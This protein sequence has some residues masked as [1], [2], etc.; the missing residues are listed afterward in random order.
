MP[1]RAA[2]PLLLTLGAA[3][4]L[5]GA[6]SAAW[7]DEVY[8]QIEAERGEGPALERAQDWAQSFSELRGF[9]LPGGWFGLVLGPLERDEAVAR[10][11]ELKAQ[12]VIP[13]DSFIAEGD[14]YRAPFWP[15][16][17]APAGMESGA[18][19]VTGST[20]TPPPET[21]TPTTTTPA[22]VVEPE[23]EP[24]PDPAQLLAEARRAGRAAEAELDRADRM[25]LQRLL[26]FAGA[27]RG[28]IDGDFGPGTRGAIREWQ[29][30]AGE[31]VTGYLTPAQIKALNDARRQA[32]AELGMAAL[33]APRTGIAM[34][35]PL[36]LM[37]FDKMAP[38]FAIWRGKNG[39]G[40][41]M[42]LF[43]RRGNGGDMTALGDLIAALDIM[44]ANAKRR[45]NK[46]GFTIEGE[47]GTL[48]S[49]AEARLEDGVIRGFVLV[50]P[51]G[52]EARHSTVL[53]AM[54]DS[55]TPLPRGVI[56][57]PQP[58]ALTVS[59]EALRQGVEGAGPRAAGSGVY[60]SADGQA[61][62]ASAL[63]QGCSE[64]LMNGTPARLV[65]WD[66]TS[67]LALIAPQHATAP[68]QIAQISGASLP[69]KG[70]P[71]AVAG[72]SWPGALPSAVVT[73][74]QMLSPPGVGGDATLAS[75]T[76]SRQPGDTGGPLLNAAGQVAGLLLP[77]PEQEGRS[78]PPELA[79]LRTA[80]A[81]AEFLGKA[82]VT[83]AAAEVGAT[84]LAPAELAE[85]GR[86]LTV[87]ITCN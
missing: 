79:P 15:V 49:F 85:R 47:T 76:I 59:A 63:V 78:F 32:L 21:T 16:G 30:Q 46:A 51:Q 54:R 7:A 26:A 60:V 36:G 55:F 68:Q 64:L 4:S 27:Y 12:G 19:T 69:T 22:T 29:G 31:L 17:A 70:Q 61:L 39:L 42:Y 82:G 56:G 62:T 25:G 73:M 28:G 34:D 23:P 74:G 2:R 66:Q 84:A 8:I 24:E 58:G 44:P 41:E 53:E 20:A 13:D 72:F 10:M 71:V 1:R 48:T 45:D 43:S 18:S 35:A 14:R 40:I 3:L 9:A 11:A 80:G 86:V 65:S 75:A 81:M 6:W 38:P 33:D 83:P 67:G 52:D 5:G 87:E 50:W 57:M 37:K 77:L